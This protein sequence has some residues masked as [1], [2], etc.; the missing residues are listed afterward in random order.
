MED[1]QV[2]GD[3]G[4]VTEVDREEQD[5]RELAERRVDLREEAE[6]SLPHAQDTEEV[7]VT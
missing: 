5:V 2:A 6:D 1:G 4:V 3:L 7:L